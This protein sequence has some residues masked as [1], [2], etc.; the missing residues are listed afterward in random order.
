MCNQAGYL[1]DQPAAPVL[2]RLMARQ[3]GWAGGYYS[4]LA[5]LD[6]DR[7]H[8]AKV[9][10]DFDRLRRE[11][12]VEDLPG[13]VGIAHSRSNSGGDVEWGHPF[14]DCHERAAY[15]ANGHRGLFENLAR[16]NRRAQDLE[17][18]GHRFRSRSAVTIRG[19]GTAPVLADGSC[20][21]LSDLMAHLIES[22]VEP[23]GSPSEA[24]RLAYSTYPA[25]IAGLL[26]HAAAP[27]CLIATRISQPLVLG[28]ACHG[29]Y[30]ATTALAFAEGEVDTWEALPPCTTATIYRDRV[31]LRPLDA[32]PGP[33]SP[34]LPW[35]AGVA[36]VM[37]V[38]DDGQPHGLGELLTPLAPLWPASV[39]PQKYR[40]C[41]EILEG[42]CATDRLAIDSVEVP[43]ATP[44]IPGRRHR[45]RLR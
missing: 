6:G 19:N 3:E 12:A 17:A 16:Q 18:A 39:A 38:L 15:V 30:V 44:D 35:A 23:A 21:H 13:T 8:H 7:L 1:G 25:E 32:L 33:V 9:V 26:L 37:G 43:G 24:M 11:T 22:L 4:G 29:T 10:G 2:L 20:L 40:L 36:A 27:E 42:L 45:A 14:I 31:E 34:V 41:Y 5:T 28:H